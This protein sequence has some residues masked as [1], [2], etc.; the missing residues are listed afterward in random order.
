MPIISGK[1]SV[2]QT[3]I[4]LAGLSSETA[5]LVTQAKDALGSK[6]ITL[7]Q[8]TQFVRDAA[9]PEMAKTVRALAKELANPAPAPAA[10]AVNGGNAQVLLRGGAPVGN[11]DPRKVAFMEKFEKGLNK[12]L[13]GQEAAKAVLM[14]FAQ[15]IDFD[16][17]NNISLDAVQNLLLVGPPGTGKSETARALAFALFDDPDAFVIIDCAQFDKMHKLD[18]IG[19]SPAGYVGYGDKDAAQLSQE[20]IDE[21]MKG[22][23]PVILLWDEVDKIGSGESGEDARAAVKKAF[24][25]KLTKP[26]ETGILQLGKGELNC[27]PDQGGLVNLFSSNDGVDSAKNIPEGD[28][29]REHYKQ[30]AMGPM[31]GHMHRRI[32]NVVP[33]DPHTPASL[34]Q[35]GHKLF[36]SAMKPALEDAESRGNSV[37]IKLSDELATYLGDCGLSQRDGAGAMVG[38]VTDLLQPFARNIIKGADDETTWELQLAPNL[39][40]V[41]RADLMREFRKA[42][43]AVPNQVTASDFVVGTCVNP[44]PKYNLYTGDVPADILAEPIIH[45]SGHVGGSGFLIENQGAGDSLNEMFMLRAAKV[46]ASDAYLPIALPD[47]IANANVSISAVN[48]D[49]DRLLVTALNLPDKGAA[50]SVAFIYDATKKGAAAWKAVS[51]P[52]PLMGA[53]LGGAEGH[54]VLVGGRVPERDHDGSWMI[55]QEQLNGGLIENVA[56]KF[57]AAKDAWSKLD[58]TPVKGRANMGVTEVEGKLWFIG[59]EEVVRSAS[60]MN[61]SASSASVDI[62]DPKSGAW[63]KGPDLL[64]PLTK[65]TVFKDP[66]G[67]VL[68]AGG[69]KLEDSGLT[70]TCQ[71]ATLRLDPNGREHKWKSRMELPGEASQMLAAIPHPLGLIV[72]PLVD[73]SGER[74]FVRY[75]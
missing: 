14:R 2:N 42:S 46:E 43:P 23:T 15:N 27:S 17:D 36:A 12:Y 38:Y 70:E 63:S 11:V 72:G 18:S 19:G 48:L 5:A 58:A 73:D 75:G 50:E 10:G 37:R 45:T 71:S 52:E 9:N 66:Y 68:V 41:A 56:Y 62:L 55:S 22:R 74:Q 39:S 32:R 28:A 25:N 59:G 26:T 13:I 69:I 4:D 53:S 67:R 61:I 16:R 7:E 6:D 8:V 60:R 35:I 31:P 30:A 54:V 64:V 33:Y 47:A 20:R 49:D 65:P 51:P 3:N 21:K 24:W 57:D 29:L 1:R 40:D 34:A 44:Q